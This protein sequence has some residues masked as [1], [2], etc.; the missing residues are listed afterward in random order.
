MRQRQR[1]RQIKTEIERGRQTDRQ[2]LREAAVV[3]KNE[4]NG[5]KQERQR[6]ELRKG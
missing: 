2:T 5:R 1:Q 4:K 6:Y 3:K